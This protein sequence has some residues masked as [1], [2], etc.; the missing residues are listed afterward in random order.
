MG[1]VHVGATKASSRSSIPSSALLGESLTLF[2]VGRWQCV[3]FVFFL[4]ALPS[5]FKVLEQAESVS[6]KWSTADSGRVLSHACEGTSNGAE[7][8]LIT[9]FASII[10]KNP[11]IVNIISKKLS[12]ANIVCLLQPCEEI[13]G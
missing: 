3:G 9:S 12:L 2:Q 6:H 7:D 10:P 1:A 11:S 13:I 8:A 5:K 4:V